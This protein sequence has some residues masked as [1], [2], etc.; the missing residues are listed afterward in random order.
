MSTPNST[1]PARTHTLALKYG[2]N[3]PAGHTA[4][5]TVVFGGT[6]M[7]VLKGLISPRSTKLIQVN[8]EIVDWVDQ[9]STSV[10]VIPQ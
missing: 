8:S 4:G 5:E 3:P 10:D 2:T 9:G 7:H 6:K 1:N